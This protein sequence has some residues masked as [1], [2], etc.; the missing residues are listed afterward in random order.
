MGTK[1]IKLDKTILYVIKKIKD[2]H[3]R[4]GINR[5]FDKFTKI[6]DFQHITKDSLCDRVNQLLKSNQL[7][8]KINRRKEPFFLKEDMIGMSII[9]MI[10]YIQH[11]PS[12]KIL[13]TSEN[14]LDSFEAMP[15]LPMQV[16][17]I[18][19]PKEAEDANINSNKIDQSEYFDNKTFKKAKFNRL[20]TIIF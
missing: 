17:L 10:P 20:K 18:E 14:R 6:L 11:S 12:S 7:I 8:N 19:T 9:D 13:D 3:Q 1:F 4:A 2:Q 16:N 15:S 5:I